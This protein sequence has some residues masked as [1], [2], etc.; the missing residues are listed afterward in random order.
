METQVTH[1]SNP[2][3][4]AQGSYMVVTHPSVFV[5]HP[6]VFGTSLGR[7][8]FLYVKRG[9]KSILHAEYT[10]QMFSWIFKFY[11][12]V[13]NTTSYSLVSLAVELEQDCPPEKLFWFNEVLPVGMGGDCTAQRKR[14]IHNKRGYKEN[15]ISKITLYMFGKEKGTHPAPF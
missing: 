1:R 12:H 4:N 3:V 13:L 6:S 5:T 8:L 9:F 15:Y 7:C 10:L 14:S 2:T 11:G